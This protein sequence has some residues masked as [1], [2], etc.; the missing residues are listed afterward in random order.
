MRYGGT[1]LNDRVIVAAGGGGW[2]GGGGGGTC[3]GGGSSAGGG[4][5][6]IGGVTNGSTQSGINEGHGK[7]VLSWP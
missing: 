6:Y 3:D 7:I 5:S 1:S 2:Y 4:S